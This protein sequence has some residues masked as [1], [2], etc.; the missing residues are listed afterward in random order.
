MPNKN[1]AEQHAKRDVLQDIAKGTVHDDGQQATTD[2]PYVDSEGHASNPL[3]ESVPDQSPDA[4]GTAAEAGDDGDD[5]NMGGDDV[6]ESSGK[7]DSTKTWTDPGFSSESVSARTNAGDTNRSG[8]QPFDIQSNPNP[9]QPKNIFS[10]YSSTPEE[11]AARFTPKQYGTPGN[12]H[13]NQF[14]ER[15]SGATAGGAA[16]VHFSG[17]T[18]QP[19]AAVT[20]DGNA[21]RAVEA[22]ISESTRANFDTSALQ[23]QAAAIRQPVLSVRAAAPVL[24]PLMPLERVVTPK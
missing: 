17:T 13:P 16:N 20:L 8:N 11:V 15:L 19:V 7:D 21:L 4:G 6:D 22:A 24:V 3:A 9:V 18:D 12:L 1:D 2:A 23:A 5:D 10:R 14:G